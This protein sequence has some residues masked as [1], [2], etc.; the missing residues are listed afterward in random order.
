M[1]MKTITM[2]MKDT[3]K[4][5]TKH[6]TNIMMIITRFILFPTISKTYNIQIENM[7]HKKL[8]MKIVG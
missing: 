3:H 2:A 8:Q 7:K 1:K 4:K 5:E 6:Q